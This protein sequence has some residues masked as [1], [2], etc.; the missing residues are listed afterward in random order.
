[1]SD[2]TGRNEI[3]IACSLAATDLE[4]RLAEWR[5]LRADA[6]ISEHSEGHVVTSVWRRDADA[7]A[8]LRALV[9]AER[10][11]CPFL[12][13]ELAEEGEVVRLTTTFLPGTEE[14]PGL[15]DD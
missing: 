11:C 6:L 13:F 10:E 5:D 15:F 14:L 3:S 1:M 9:D 4:A 12:G 2:T 8:R 7:E